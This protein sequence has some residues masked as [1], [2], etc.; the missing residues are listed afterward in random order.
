MHVDIQFNGCLLHMQD[1]REGQELKAE[2]SRLS[3]ELECTRSDLVQQRKHVNHLA[4]KCE[5]LEFSVAS[6]EREKVA[7]QEANQK[8]HDKI[9]ELQR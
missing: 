7:L 1:S 2:N 6:L 3:D 8:L 9:L 5:C 4:E